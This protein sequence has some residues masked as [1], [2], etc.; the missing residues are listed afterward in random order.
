MVKKIKIINKEVGYEDLLR[1]G[2]TSNGM[3]NAIWLRDMIGVIPIDPFI[4]V[5]EKEE[6]VSL[7]HKLIVEQLGV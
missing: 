7:I 5:S 3:D 1:L 6:R 4:D 2:F